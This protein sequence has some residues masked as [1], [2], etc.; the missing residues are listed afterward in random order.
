MLSTIGQV[1]I[2]VTNV[3]LAIAFYRDKLGMK[4]LYQFPNLA[5]FDCSGVRLMLSVA[6]K[7]TETYSSVIYFKVPDIT[8]EY[9][10]MKSRGVSFEDEPHLIAPMR[11]YDLWM[12]FFRD[13]DRNLL[14]VMCEVPRA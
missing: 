13:L 14:A 3:D 10:T 4:F 11:D 12:V 2:T 5:F 1:G 7:P 9:E 6:E 8:A